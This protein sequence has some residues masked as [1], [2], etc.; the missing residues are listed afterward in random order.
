[1]NVRDP[2]RVWR[3]FRVVE[4]R[5]KGQVR[6]HLSECIKQCAD[7][8]GVWNPRVKLFVV[9][10]MQMRMWS[11][12]VF[13]KHVFKHRRGR[14]DVEGQR[15]IDGCPLRTV[16]Y[17]AY[18]AHGYTRFDNN[19]LREHQQL[20]RIW[21]SS[22]RASSKCS[23][24]ERRRRSRVPMSWAMGR[25]LTDLLTYKLHKHAACCGHAR[26]A[27]RRGTCS[28]G[29]LNPDCPRLKSTGKW[30]QWWTRWLAR[31]GMADHQ[32][33]KHVEDVVQAFLPPRDGVNLEQEVEGIGVASQ[34]VNSMQENGFSF[35]EGL[36]QSIGVVA[37]Q[38]TRLGE[39]RWSMERHYD[40]KF[41]DFPRGNASG[42]TG[43]LVRDDIIFEVLR[44]YWRRLPGAAGSPGVE[45]CWIRV[46]TVNGWLYL[47]SVYSPNDISVPMAGIAADA[48]RR[49]VDAF[50]ALDD[51]VGVLVSG[52]FNSTW[53]NDERLRDRRVMGNG[54]STPVG[55]GRRWRD[56]LAEGATVV[57]D[58]L[59]RPYAAGNVSMAN[60]ATRFGANGARSTCIDYGVWFGPPGNIASVRM[61]D[62]TG[63]DHRTLCIRLSEL[64]AEVETL[65]RFRFSKLQNEDTKK[66]F[67]EAVEAAVAELDDDDYP[68]LITAIKDALREVCGV[69]RR[70]RRL[71]CRHNNWWSKKLAGMVKRKKVWQRRKWRLARRGVDVTWLS[72]KVKVLKKKIQYEL[73]AAQSKYWRGVKEEWDLRGESMH[74]A[75]GMLRRSS[76]KGTGVQ[77][78][79]AEMEEAW[80]SIFQTPPPD[81]CE[82]GESV[83]EL[84]Q[85]VWDAFPDAALVSEE[86]LSSVLKLTPNG[87]A[88]GGD[89]IPNEVLKALPPLAVEALASCFNSFLRQ[90]EDIPA[91]WKTSL[92]VMI[93]KGDQIE[94]ALDYRPITL[95]SCVAKSLELVLWERVKTLGIP[96]DVWQGGFRAERGCPELTWVLK[97]LSEALRERNAKGVAI[98]LDL[99][100]AY[101][102]VPHFSLVRKL[103]RDF[104]QLPSYFLKFL[105]H[106]IRGH[107]RRLAVDGG[108]ASDLDVARGLPQGG[109]LS[110]VCFNMF[111]ND[112]LVL[113]KDALV[114]VSVDIQQLV[115]EVFGFSLKA[116]AFADDL[117]SLVR[118]L[119]DARRALRI[120]EEWAVTN[121]LSFNPGKCKYMNI[122][123]RFAAI[124]NW[125]LR[126]HDGAVDKCT[127]F[128]YLGV[129]FS[130]NAASSKWLKSDRFLDEIQREL[131]K[132]FV[133][134]DACHGCPVFVGL[135]IISLRFLPKLLYGAEVFRIQSRTQLRDHQ[136]LWAGLGKRVL[137]GYRS[138]SNTLAIAFLGLRNISDYRNKRIIKFCLKMLIC[139]YEFLWRPLEAVLNSELPWMVD[140]R[141]EFRSARQKGMFVVRDERAANVGQDLLADL[142]L[143]DFNGFLTDQGRFPTRGDMK[144]YIHKV[145]STYET[146]WERSKPRPHPAVKHAHVHGHMAFR[147]LVGR[148]NPRGTRDDYPC[149]LCNE[150]LADEP[151][152]LVRCQSAKVQAILRQGMEDCGV[153]PVDR[154]EFLST[155]AEPT[156]ARCN[157]LLRLRPTKWD[158]FF[159]VMRNLWHARTREWKR[160]YGHHPGV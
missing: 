9:W 67:Q 7:F 160:R 60:W 58:R 70:R 159:R 3:G 117:I 119:E 142:N 147:F 13:N 109:I 96:L 40:W 12:G 17:N 82:E 85:I 15:M 73:G 132:K 24:R 16:L 102:C 89:G 77:H 93:P 134:Y 36:D 158:V 148:F 83:L 64:G 103:R 95:L 146:N 27:H 55:K 72:E 45:W 139:R 137:G 8:R 156:A 1:M 84:N 6:D 56:R 151:V 111:I 53:Y 33:S 114:G 129:P 104:P 92:V 118:S 43:F 22:Q 123:S 10:D 29:Y 78:S 30:I 38:E 116:M 14:M 100:K 127:E 113:L 2:R 49:H 47:A 135:T 19:A 154:E 90:P 81:N 122:G 144:A 130:S 133:I 105:F 87:K 44:P 20:V 121:G 31:R 97:I 11:N 86:E 51:C 61:R 141:A 128:Q 91:E 25:K 52:D 88:A 152:H 120:C 35:I 23:L 74:Q 101:D 21:R 131:K 50:L 34:N 41:V 108:S 125:N 157:S 99:R 26:L 79:R 54:G 59:V 68:G 107:V 124:N 138:D 57:N 155:M 63:P 32:A 37:L 65:E 62:A 140:L 66:Q 149:V 153:H 76:S 18:I 69:Q 46:R 136:K 80:G 48:L 39:G 42:G 126:I 112:L 98:F 94:S 110:P 115:G 5:S 106:W 28:G 150:P 71:K 75:F 4:G 143:D 145:M